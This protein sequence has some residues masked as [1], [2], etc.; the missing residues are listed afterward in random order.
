MQAAGS[1][2]SAHLLHKALEE[3]QSHQLIL[4]NVAAALLLGLLVTWSFLR[5]PRTTGSIVLAW[6]CWFAWQLNRG[7]SAWQEVLQHAQAAATSTTRAIRAVAEMLAAWVAL[8]VP[9]LED[10]YLGRHGL[11]MFHYLSLLWHFRDLFF[12][13]CTHLDRHI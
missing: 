7:R 11:I 10:L 5:R 12:L 9:A 6:L 3:V 1:D 4:C 2:P 8:F 13:R